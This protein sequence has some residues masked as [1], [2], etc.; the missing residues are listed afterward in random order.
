MVSEGGRSA[1][2]NLYTA[3]RRPPLVAG[4]TTF[5]HGKACHWI[6]ARLLAPYESSSLATG[7][8]V[9]LDSQSPKGSL[10][11]Q[12]PCH[13]RKR[14]TGFSV[15]PRAPYESSSLAT[16]LKRW[17]YGR[18]AVVFICAWNSSEGKPYNRAAPVGNAPLLVLRTTSP[19]GKHVTGFSGRFAPLQIQFLCHPGGGSFRGAM[20]CDAYEFIGSL[21]VVVS[22]HSGVARE[23][24][25]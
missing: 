12:F 15:A 24:D 25:S 9:S 5:L 7:G 20:L 6:L 3:F 23:H 22:P 8:S 16:P 19:K 17:D 13:R 21:R 2:A 4:A 14:V 10:R 18:W 1:G 11:I